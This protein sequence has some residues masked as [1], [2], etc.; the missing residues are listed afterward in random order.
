MLPYVE[1]SATVVLVVE[2]VDVLLVLVV[3]VL[4][5]LDVVVVL[6]T[7]LWQALPAPITTA[8]IATHRNSST[9]TARILQ[10]RQHTTADRRPHV[11]CAA[12]R[13]VVRASSVMQ[14]LRLRRL[15]NWATQRTYCPWFTAA[16]HGQDTASAAATSLG[17]GMGSGLPRP[18][19]T[20]AGSARKRTSP[21]RRR[22]VRIVDLRGGSGSKV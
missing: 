15:R 10:G 6:S 17:H 21:I 22:D 20:L 14:P 8:P 2:E 4:E 5:L 11:E 19:I 13:I 1:P 7:Q 12:Q 9:T 16:S 3:L 18:A